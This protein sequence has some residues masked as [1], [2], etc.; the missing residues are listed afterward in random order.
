MKSGRLVVIVALLLMLPWSAYPRDDGGPKYVAPPEIIAGLP[1]ICWWLYMDNVPNTPEFN[2]Q[3]ED[4][5]GFT[6]HFCPGLV[7]MKQA[8]TEKNLSWALALLRM[9][10]EDM[11]Y[12]INNT[13]D[14]PQCPVRTPARQSLQ[15]ISFQMDMIQWKARKR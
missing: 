15:K 13:N 3:L 1:R 4:C 8:E 7:K 5:G 9:A 11:E 12:T 14:F 6:N 2:P 10:K